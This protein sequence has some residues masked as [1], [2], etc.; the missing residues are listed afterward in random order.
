MTQT[1]TIY[2]D[3]TNK[4]TMTALHQ[5]KNKNNDI[6]HV[7]LTIRTMLTAMM[8]TVKKCRFVRAWICHFATTMVAQLFILLLPRDSLP[9]WRSRIMITM[10]I[11]V[12]VI[13]MVEGENYD[14]D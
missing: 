5:H 12:F 3:K 9:V 10:I 13:V 4:T 8:K 1:K 14:H 11:I 2:K 6:S 7:T